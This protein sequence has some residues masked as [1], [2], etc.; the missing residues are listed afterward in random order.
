MGKKR[1]DWKRIKTE[2]FVVK[3]LNNLTTEEKKIIK[4]LKIDGEYEFFG[5]KKRNLLLKFV[6]KSKQDL[7]LYKKIEK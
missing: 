5:D 2:E 4:K 7:Y 6:K 3:Q 1:D